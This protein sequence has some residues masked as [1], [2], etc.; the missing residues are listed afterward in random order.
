MEYVTLGVGSLLLV[1]AII[2]GLLHSGLTHPLAQHCGWLD[3]SRPLFLAFLH[4]G[5]VT[6]PRPA[7][8]APFCF[9]LPRA[10]PVFAL[11]ARWFFSGCPGR[12]WTGC[13]PYS[14]SRSTPSRSRVALLLRP[15]PNIINQLTSLS[16]LLTCVVF[17]TFLCLSQSAS[18]PVR[19]A[20]LDP[21][22]HL[23]HC[24]MLSQ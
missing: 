6:P 5:V 4:S 12:C 22:Q 9:Y 13:V 1:S 15:R 19:V 17:L 8:T 21:V 14:H 10:H 24:A 3:S 18:S 2:L 11:G 16:S 7:G 23:S 20:R